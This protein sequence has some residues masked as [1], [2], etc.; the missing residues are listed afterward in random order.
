[1]QKSAIWIFI[2]AADNPIASA[3]HRNVKSMAIIVIVIVFS[4]TAICGGAA[5]YIAI[6]HEHN[7]TGH[8]SNLFNT[9]IAMFSFGM[10]ALVGLVGGMRL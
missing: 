9:A 7:L 10:G 5:F 1:L 8:Q 2:E 3:D 6:W 4:L